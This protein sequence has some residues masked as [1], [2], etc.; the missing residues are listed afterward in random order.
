MWNRIVLVPRYLLALAVAILFC[1][2]LYWAVVGSLRQV[3]LPPATSVEW[4]PRTP[5]WENYVEIFRTVPMARYLLN[6]LAVVAAAVPI[7]W[8][9][10][11]LAGFAMAQLPD[12]PRRH[13]FRFSV[14]LLLV[15]AMSV[16]LLRYRI[17]TYIGLVDTLW[18]LIVPAVAANPLFV[19]IFYW[20]FR[21][22]PA[23][24]YE[25][26]RLDGAGAL[27]VWWH[28]ARPLSWPASAAVLVLSFFTYW[29]DMSSP[30]LYIYRPTRYTVPI[31]LQL[32]N[33]VDPTN[34]PLL[35]AGAVF[36]ILPVALLFLFLQRYFLHDLSLRSIFDKG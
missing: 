23:E 30:V 27:G 11:A 24:L 5:H 15:P 22:I 17:L 36:T 8:L 29:G 3:G 9:T 13:L 35:M 2:P 32:L 1:L 14:L 12:G 33:Q 31:G 18:A 4:W 10:S 6:S 20:T 19:L 21:R 28:I 7:S 16:W 25:A 26:A 34:L